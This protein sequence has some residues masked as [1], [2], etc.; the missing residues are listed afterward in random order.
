MNKNT[1]R[2][3]ESALLLAIATSLEL[4]S[5]ALAF[6]LPFGGT[7]TLA[8]M[9]PVILISYKYGLKWGFLSAFVYSLIQMALGARVISAMF[10]PG[11]DQMVLW[12][13]LCVCL[14]DYIVA[15][16]ILGIGGFMRK[17]TKSTVL[18]LVLGVPVALTLRY[19]VHILSGFIFYGAWAEWFFSQEGFYAIGQKI[20][21][22]F[23][24][25]GLSLIYSVFYNGLYMVPEI[26]LTS[27]VAAVLGS[28]SAVKKLI[29]PVDE[30]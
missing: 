5:K 3:V 6:E 29:A 19:L 7:I 12:Q 17:R 14:L 18:A 9:L 13:A 15:Y 23:S 26:I 10:L 28:V 16:T 1:K 11:E 8:S 25:A 22:T 27:I 20:L 21:E 4:I 30:P 2:L 24:G